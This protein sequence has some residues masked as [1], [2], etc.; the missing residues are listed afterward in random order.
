MTIMITGATGQLGRLIITELLQK[1]PAS[2]LIAGVR[3][4]D[5]AAGLQQSGV[6]IRMADYDVPESL[7]SAFRTISRLLLISSPHQDDTV[8]LLQHKRVIDAAR[9]AGVEHIFY[10]GFA[11]SH[12][13]SPDNVHTLTE[14][15]IADSGLKYTFLRNALYLDFIN[16]L[17]LQ[18][19]ISSGVLLTSPG[20]WRFNSVTR[21]D[22]AQAT[23]AVLLSN[24]HDHPSYEFTAPQAW[25]FHDLAEA[26]S[27]RAGKTVVHREDPGIQHWIYNYL[28]SINT[29]ATTSDLER[30]IGRPVTPLKKSI[31]DFVIA[32][33]K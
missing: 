4:P 5:K 21:R 30:W 15:A 3:N 12:Q 16:V 2:Q 33:Q 11:F 19:A 17:G 25:T 31:A 29:S 20:E 9:R 7:D 18:E 32:G 28:A 26:L 13:G 1:I 24:Q 8:R 27:E 6:E 14:Q 22:L 23:A 10:T